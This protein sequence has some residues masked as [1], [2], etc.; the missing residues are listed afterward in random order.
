LESKK[1]F[2]GICLGAQ[3]LARALGATVAPHPDSL[4]EIGYFPVIPTLA[5]QEQFS[6]PIHLYHWNLEGFEIPQGAALLA[7]GKTFS[8]QAFR[9]GEVAYGVQFHPEVTAEMV[10]KWTSLGAEQLILPGAQSR[11]EQMQRYI[12]YNQASQDWLKRF[13][14]V[15]LG[16]STA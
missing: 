12:L 15:W 13:L 6:E 2:L 11:E 4:A 5:G 7:E 1:P 16:K 8:H 10:D 9:Y 14:D 3:L